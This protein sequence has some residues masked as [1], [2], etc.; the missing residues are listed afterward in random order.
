MEIKLSKYGKIISTD[1]TSKTILKEIESSLDNNE[2]ININ[3]LGVVI[4]TK[5]ARL[6]FG[7]LYKKLTKIKFN[8]K[9]HFKNASTSFM[10]AVNEG[11][12]TELESQQFETH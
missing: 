1:D 7:I 4:S 9:I 8:S 6:I 5:S 12:L 2:P 3:A 11:I 10:F